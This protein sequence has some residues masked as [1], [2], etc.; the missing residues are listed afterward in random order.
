MRKLN[1]KRELF[2]REYLI[3]FNAS[4]SYKA[5]YGGGPDVCKAAGS[6]LLNNPR[7]QARLKELCAAQFK[8][9]DTDA[10]EVL[11]EV[12]RIALADAADAFNDDGT[13]KSIQD[14]PVDLRRVIAGFEVVEQYNGEVKTGAI[15][16]VKFWSKDHQLENLMKYL[17]LFAENNKQAGE[18]AAAVLA[19]MIK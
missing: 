12:R 15:K 11:L 4:Q 13:V 19:P 9:T 14:I 6:R 1:P 17:G 5:V 16:K 2:C 8:R 18:A 10:D 3:T 7:I